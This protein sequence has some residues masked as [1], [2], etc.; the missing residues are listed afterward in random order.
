LS[1]LLIAIAAV[2]AGVLVFMFSFSEMEAAFASMSVVLRRAGLAVFLV[3]EIASIFVLVR[4]FLKGHIVRSL[5][6]CVSICWGSLTTVTMGLFLGLWIK[7]LL[8][9][10]CL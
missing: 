7:V 6:S 3:S 8:H 1:A 5:Q 2:S 4:A 10:Q 9:R